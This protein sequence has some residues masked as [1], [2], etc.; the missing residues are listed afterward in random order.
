MSACS[1]SLAEYDE[2][3]DLYVE[4]TRTS[5]KVH[6]CC[7]CGGEIR[8]GQKYQHVAGKWYMAQGIITYKTCAL[9]A[10]IRGKFSSSGFLFCQ[11]WEEITEYLFPEIN[12]ECMNGLSV[13]AHNKILERWAEWKGLKSEGRE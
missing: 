5:R 1:F 9:C 12:F 10:E 13:E 8:P 7:E 11:L 4:S 3:S 6:K 2:G